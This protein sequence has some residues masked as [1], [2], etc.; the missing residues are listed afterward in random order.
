VLDLKKTFGPGWVNLGP[1]GMSSTTAAS[2]P[3]PDIVW[4]KTVDEY[5][6]SAYRAGA[7]VFGHGQKSP[8]SAMCGRLETLSANSNID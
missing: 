6:T 2:P 1:I 5:L 7:D 8:K 4:R 3:I